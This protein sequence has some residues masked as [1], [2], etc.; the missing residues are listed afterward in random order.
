[1]REEREE[2]GLREV[3]DEE[4]KAQ[5]A[6]ERQEKD[7]QVQEE[8][9]GEERRWT[10]KECAGEKDEEECRN[11]TNEDNDV[12]NRHMTWWRRSW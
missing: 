10:Q 9:C 1:M 4:R 11:S 8:H 2:K 3:R 5:E 6:R 12:S 7:I